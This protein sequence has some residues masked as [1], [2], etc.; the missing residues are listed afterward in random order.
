[1]QLPAVSIGINILRVQLTKIAKQKTASILIPERGTS[2]V[3][4][5][6]FAV[7]EKKEKLL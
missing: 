4:L 1:M 5:R 6:K 7:L 2:E 3:G